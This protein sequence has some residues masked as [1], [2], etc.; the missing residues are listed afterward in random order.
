MPNPQ[1]FL[2]K[3]KY[4]DGT[5]CAKLL[6]YE[7]NDRGAVP[8]PDAGTQAI[9]DQ[10]TLVGELAQQLYP[11]G[12]KVGREKWPEETHAKSQ[13]ALKL[14]KPLFEAGLTYSRAYALPDILVPVEDNAWDLIE[15]KSGTSVEEVHL[16]D[17]AFQKYVY[18]GAGLKIRRC[19][20]MYINTEYLRKGEIEPKKLFTK[21]DISDEIKPYQA[22]LERSIK[23]MLDVISGR[24]PK[25]KI[26]PQ[27]GKPY[28]CPLEEL[29]WGFLP[30]GDIFQLCGKKA[31]LFDLLDEGIMK[32]IDVP[33]DGLSDKQLIQVQSHRTGKAHVDREGI[34]AF[35]DE[36]KYPLYFLDFETIA[37]AIPIYDL[38]HPYETMPFQFSLHIVQKEGAKPVHHAYLA[39]GDAD[40]R[41]EV[42][43]RLKDLLG[44]S[45]TVLAYNMTFEINCL[46]NA[47]EAYPEYKG[48]FEKLLKR[49][50]DLLSPFRSLH[51]YHPAQEGS[52]SIKYV[53]PAMTKT[54][55]AGMEIADGGTASR[56]YARVTFGSNIEAKD[57]QKVRQALEAYCQLDTQAMID[58]LEELKRL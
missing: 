6:W 32:I 43:K 12:I 20:L 4:L 18:T 27:C 48:W 57:R 35:L 55:Y 52:A 37:P 23:E 11:D 41:P 16:M 49:F 30:E 31:R 17:V 2:S 47:V 10:G 3:T 53:L 13:A 50:I 29:C 25:V 24:E 44:S 7:F 56:E 51:Y 34:R 9:F 15:V 33:L 8:K 1:P 26:G 22:G 54:S 38:S 45:G 42:L 46:R 40:P 28:G 14:R 39:P 36:L 58:V 19:Y 5:K 21:K